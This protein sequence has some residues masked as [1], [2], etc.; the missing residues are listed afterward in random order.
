MVVASGQAAAEACSGLAPGDCVLA[1]EDD[2]A[3][4]KW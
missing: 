3:L 1:P 2:W 4:R